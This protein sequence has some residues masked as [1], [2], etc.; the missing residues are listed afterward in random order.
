MLAPTS[1]PCITAPVCNAASVPTWVALRAARRSAAS[2]AAPR[3][4]AALITPRD[5]IAPAPT[6]ERIIG[7]SCGA[8]SARNVD[9]SAGSFTVSPRDVRKAS[10]WP[11]FSASCT[12]AA[13]CASRALSPSDLRDSPYSCSSLPAPRTPVS[14]K[15]PVARP[16]S[17]PGSCTTE[18][19]PETR[20]APTSEAASP[21][22]RSV[23]PRSGRDLRI[24]ALASAGFTS[25]GMFSTS[26]PSG[27]RME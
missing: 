15:S 25:S 7:M 8:C 3:A 16:Y 9:R 17:C 27:K 23:E 14:R 6:P 10:N 1:A 12:L 24:L 21:Q 18:P 26:V 13:R 5:A 11:S 22:V 19:R 2:F 4:A 20:P